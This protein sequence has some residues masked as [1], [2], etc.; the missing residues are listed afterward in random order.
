LKGSL[1]KIAA[2]TK[3]ELIEAIGQALAGVS[4]E[5]VRGF[6]NHCGYRDP[7]QQL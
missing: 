1:R 2:R 4:A 7:A 3:D 5:D 6:F